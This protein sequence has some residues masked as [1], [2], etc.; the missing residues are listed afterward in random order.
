VCSKRRA[1]SLLSRPALPRRHPPTR[2]RVRRVRARVGTRG[3]GG[4]DSRQEY[5]PTQAVM[6][7]PPEVITESA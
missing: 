6:P 5:L 7:P 4:S 3:T 1:L 2:V